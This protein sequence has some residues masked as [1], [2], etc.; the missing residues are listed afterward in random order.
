MLFQPAEQGPP[1]SEQ[2]GA[3]EMLAQGIFERCKREAVFGLHVFRTLNAGQVGYRSGPMMA[4][5]DRFNIVIKG[6]RRMARGPR[7][8]AQAHGATAVAKVPENEGNPVTINNPALAAR[9]AES[10]AKAVAAKN[11]VEM[12]LIMG[13]GDFNRFASQVPGF[14]FRVGATPPGQD[15]VKAPSNHSPEFLLVEE[16]LRVGTRGMLQIVL[17]YQRSDG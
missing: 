13:A 5:S 15:A 12:D 7:S 4:A 8:V 16:A 10:L 11:V 2:G 9:A 1:D 14:F 6:R 17:D 3:S